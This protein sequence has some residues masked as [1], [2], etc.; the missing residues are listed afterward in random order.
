M[1]KLPFLCATILIGNFLF[2]QSHTLKFGTLLPINNKAITILPTTPNDDGLV[3][4]SKPVSHNVVL[5]GGSMNPLTNDGNNLILSNS[6]SLKN[7][8]TQAPLLLTPIPPKQKT[9]SGNSQKSTSLNTQSLTDNDNNSSTSLTDYGTNNSKPFQSSTNNSNNF[10]SLTYS[11]N[12]VA[13]TPAANVSLEPLTYTAPKAKMQSGLETL[14]PSRINSS[15]NNTTNSQKSVANSFSKNTPQETLP[16]RYSVARTKMPELAPIEGATD[17]VNSSNGYSKSQNSG[18]PE[19][20]PIEGQ[21]NATTK[22]NQ[23]LMPELAPLEDEQTEEV[24]QN[25]NKNQDLNQ[26]KPNKVRGFVIPKGT[27][28]K[29]NETKS[30]IIKPAAP[31]KNIVPFKPNDSDE[32][33]GTK[34]SAGGGF[35]FLA[36]KEEI[37]EN[38]VSLTDFIETPTQNNQTQQQL[39][40]AAK[41][42]Q[43][44]PNNPC[45]RVQMNNPAKKKVAYKKPV[46]RKKKIYVQQPAVVYAYKQDPVKTQNIERIVYVPIQQTQ[47]EPKKTVQVYKPQ[48]TTQSAQPTKSQQKVVYRDYTNTYTK[49]N[50]STQPENIGASKDSK[51]YYNPNNYANGL[52]SGPTSGDYPVA[53]NSS[54]VDMKYTFYVNPRGKYGVSIYNNNC[55]VLLQQNG[56]VVEFKVYGDAKTEQPKLNHF[57]SPESIAGIPIEYNYNRSVHKIG[58]I[59]F[60]YDFEGFFK[61][62]GNSNVF[63]T[64]RSTLSRVDNTNVRYDASGNVTSVDQNSGIVQYNP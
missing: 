22:A 41:N 16:P 9:T 27:L 32:L 14:D 15:L 51:K 53:G 4:A 58:N 11:P 43:H 59:K 29:A 26:E 24:K 57:G 8:G 50:P 48:L 35:S 62:V 39:Q 12:S 54:D 21:N 45:C 63:Y 19:L 6:N 23:S 13:Q 46:Y 28:L 10:Q 17:V 49:S 44:D 55:S 18:M 7:T 60:D 56:K 20:A 34:T 47:Q 40:Q 31:I 38:Y 64:S 5:V 33:I 25:N 42:H 2:G 52:N 36:D 3:I 1:K 61:S 37:N 30:Y